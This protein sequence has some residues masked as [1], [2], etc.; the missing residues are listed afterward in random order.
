VH[1]GHQVELSEHDRLLFP[2]AEEVAHR[3]A[4]VGD[5]ARIRDQLA[6]W[7]SAGIT[8]VAYQPAGPDIP[9]E[10]ERFAEAALGR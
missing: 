4:L 7:E 8:E 2:G 1:A 10:L 5:P 3:A 6:E 9:A